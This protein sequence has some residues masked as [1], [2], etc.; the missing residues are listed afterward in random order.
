VPAKRL[1]RK[2][3]FTVLSENDDLDSGMQRLQA[4]GRVE[5][6]QHGHPDV[7]HHH[8]WQELAGDLD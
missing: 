3:W 7:H 4:L 1:H 2:S 6:I 5:T 8:V